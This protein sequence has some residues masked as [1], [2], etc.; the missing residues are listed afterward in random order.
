[1]P[2]L[3]AALEGERWELAALCLLEGLQA[4]LS[5]LPVDSI[6]GLLDALEGREDGEK[7]G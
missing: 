4:V 5:R 1:M 6:E 3:A 7:K 2:S